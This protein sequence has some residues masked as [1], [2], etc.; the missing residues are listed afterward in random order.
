LVFVSFPCREQLLII[1]QVEAV[2]A[3]RYGMRWKKAAA[4]HCNQ[5]RPLEPAE[6]A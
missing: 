3:R 5:D 1:L 6:K 4:R 2:E